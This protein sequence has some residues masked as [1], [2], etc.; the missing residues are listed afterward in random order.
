M[1]S[2]IL[3][4]KYAFKIF[5]KRKVFSLVVVVTLA[6]GIGSSTAIFGFVNSVLLE[7]GTSGKTVFM[8]THDIL[9]SV[10]VGTRIGIIKEG[11]L[12]KTINAASLDAR[13]L[14]ELYLQTI[15]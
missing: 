6:I 15:N 4:L 14:Q 3:N 1:E 7:L 5:S 11:N 10:D 12:L 9:N 13:Q 8:A 2:F